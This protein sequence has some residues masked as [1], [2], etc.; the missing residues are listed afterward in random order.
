M[1]I[2]Y[3][4]TILLL[5]ISFLVVK[6]TDK[7]INISI[8][9]A[10]SLI[11]LLCYN[12]LICYL[13]TLFKIPISLWLLAI[14]NIIIATILFVYAI[15]SKNI[16][17]YKVVY[18]DFI[19]ITILAIIVFVVC[20]FNF[21]YPF[22]IKYECEDSAIHFGAAKTFAKSSHIANQ[23]TDKLFNY[24]TFKFGSYVNSGLLMKA[25]SQ[26]VPQ[27]RYYTVFIW[28][29]IFIL[30]ISAYVMYA[31][32]SH[33]SKDT[34]KRILAY[35]V[36]IIYVLGYPL[37]SLLFGFEYLSMSLVII[38][39]IILTMELFKREEISYFFW[40]LSL[41]LLN[42]ELFCSYYLFVPFT[43]VAIFIYIIYLG[44]KKYKKLINKSILFTII[45]TLIIPFIMGY[46][47]HFMPKLYSLNVQNIVKQVENSTD[48]LKGFPKEG[49][50]YRNLY[51]NII[52][53]IPFTLYELIKYRKE[54]VFN[55]LL[56]I[57]CTLYIITLFIAS[58]IGIVSTYY[59]AKIY[60]A[61]WGIVIYTSF[62]GFMHLGEKNKYIPIAYVGIYI[63]F[64]I[65]ALVF[66][67]VKL[68][69]KKTNENEKITSV[70][71]IFNIN[72]TIIFN[73][74]DLNKND[75]EGLEYAKKNLDFSKKIE[76]VGNPEQLDW[77]Y[78]IIE[79]ANN[80][81]NTKGYRGIHFFKQKLINI[82][83]TISQADYIIYFKKSIYYIAN[84]KE[85]L[86]DSNVIYENESIGIIEKYKTN[87]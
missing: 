6:K 65:I 3:L 43:Y 73:N 24:T 47:Y 28:F 50:I 40:V 7:K 21:N 14:I 57:F 39:A 49:Y 70:M 87:L 82:D 4:S 84:K 23:D 75:I 31:C 64:L 32:L 79:Y 36:S 27:T 1:G 56:V 78:Q 44:Y 37:N 69:N 22:E 67:D 26:F 55:S 34:W 30:F 16:Q 33:F 41:F 66:K 83:N 54:N 76:I 58:E 59:L 19:Y 11:L 74:E 80:D 18:S 45:I 13:L 62:K 42:F 15:K 68:E 72:K 9:L 85:I 60:Y 77:T 29:E 20:I 8:M 63:L 86:K 25:V 52:L 38:S 48:V 81:E 53:W 35:I 10:L 12:A 5:L 17:S 46:I 2:L 51:S 61:F 71:E